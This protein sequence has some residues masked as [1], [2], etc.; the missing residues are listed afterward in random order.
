MVIAIAFAQH[1]PGGKVEE[2]KKIEEFVKKARK[3]FVNTIP[4]E[5]DIMLK[6]NVSRAEA[7]KILER[8]IA[9]LSKERQK[10]VT[11]ND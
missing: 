6:L 3:I 1:A 9:I 7:Q 8:L 4:N 5:E 10:G 2:R 11:E